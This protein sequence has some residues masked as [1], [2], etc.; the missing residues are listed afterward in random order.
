VMK[1]AVNYPWIELLRMP[2]RA[3]RHFGG[4]AH[5]FNAGY[6]TVKSLEFEI[7]GNLDADISFDQDHFE[8]LV[9]KFAENPSLGVAGTAFIED[10]SIAYD[11]DVV[12]IEHVSGQC[13][14]FRRKCYD[15]IGGYQ[16]IKGGGVDWTAV[17]T[18][19]MMGWET[20]TFDEK[21][22]VHHRI[23]GTGMSSYFAT[24]FRFGKQDYYLGGHPL[25]EVFRSIYQM[26]KKPFVIGGILLL[27][28]YIWAKVSGVEKAVSKDL[29]A[30]RRKEQ[31][32]RLKLLLNKLCMKNGV[33]QQA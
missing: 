30:F 21:A 26:K 4:K 17:T 7:I 14:I 8:F 2:E 29:E 23:M 27:A 9:M 25:W 18:A 33:S 3:E 12:N 22:F 15:E 32:Q 1:Y 5:A 11:Y 13:Q 24:R 6:E 28:G 19:R 20:R 31:M 10:S 16:P